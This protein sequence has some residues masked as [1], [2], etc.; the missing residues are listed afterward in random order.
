MSDYPQVQ[1]CRQCP[2]P[3]RPEKVLCAQCGIKASAYVRR[4][5]QANV[6][7]GLC[8]YGGGYCS[9]RPKKG[10]TLC[11]DH[12]HEMSV[13]YKERSRQRK[14]AR[15]CRACSQPLPDGR[16]V[17]CLDCAPTLDGKT[18]LQRRQEMEQRAAER[19]TTL[20]AEREERNRQIEKLLAAY[21]TLPLNAFRR[22]QLEI[23]AERCG[24]GNGKDRSLEDVGRQFGI[25]RERVRQIEKKIL[26]V[27]LTAF[28]K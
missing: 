18:N 13:R 5:R 25:T 12:L 15:V 26:G 19:N 8:G 7:K 11:P 27:P 24:L 9:K 1:K 23:V 4:R 22:R 16:T 2:N 21:G 10:R 17:I 6:A 20:A 14:L 3:S 28:A